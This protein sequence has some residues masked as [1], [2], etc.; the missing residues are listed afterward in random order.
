MSGDTP[1][2][3]ILLCE[4]GFLQLCL[5]AVVGEEGA[6]EDHSCAVQIVKYIDNYIF[7]EFFYRQHIV[8]Y[9]T[10]AC[11]NNTNTRNNRYNNKQ[12]RNQAE[13]IEKL[14][15]NGTVIHIFHQ[16]HTDANN[17]Y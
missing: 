11:S 3:L 17:A 6:E 15:A 5:C 14:I 12:N 7:L 9:L 10:C 1:R 8:Y 16:E 4:I 2:S 13:R